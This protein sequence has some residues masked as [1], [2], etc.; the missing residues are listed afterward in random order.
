M[1]K[2]I[3]IIPNFNSGG[4]EKVIIN[5]IN[6]LSN[7][8]KI[9]LIVFESKGLYL[10]LLNSN[11]DLIDL[12]TRKLRNSLFKI[13]SAIY[14][15]K[16]N[17][18]FSSLLH[19][20][21][22]LIFVKLF[23][24]W[25][26]KIILRESNMPISNTKRNKKLYFC[27]RYLYKISNYIV[28]SSYIMRD[29]FISKFKIKINKIRFIP[30]PIIFEKETKSTIPKNFFYKNKINLLSIGRLADQKNYSFMIDSFLIAKNENAILNIFGEGINKE[31]LLEQINKNNLSD[32]V[33]L[34]GVYK[35]INLAYNQSDIL[36]ICSKWEG[37][38]NVMLEAL[39]RGLI[40]ISSKD[41][42]GISE[43]KKIYKNKL[44]FYNN[45]KDLIRIIKSFTLK[46][47]KNYNKRIF[48]PK[49]Y[50]INNIRDL[51]IN[52]IEK[53]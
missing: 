20:N 5:I 3:F 6:L 21:I 12:K 50:S 29:E 32:K 7:K 13:V 30:N 2:L 10:N 49:E 42:G 11:I 4:A 46:E 8:Y 22:Y 18:V 39:F 48:I 28:A 23:F 14:K 44:F 31:I 40:V 16:P 36:I 9:S 15:I 38:S 41:A 51:Y 35:D 24:Y 17:F 27:Y 47:H 45:K 37:M 52:L 53:T 43:L 19:I 34:R 25:N 26:L 33:F 1:K